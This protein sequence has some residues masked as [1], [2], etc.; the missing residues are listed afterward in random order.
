[1]PSGPIHD[2]AG[3]FQLAERL[4][5][6]PVADAAGQPTVANPIGL[7]RTPATY[8]LAPPPLGGDVVDLDGQV[9]PRVDGQ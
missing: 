4:G 7:S 9:H 3:A 5:L 6:A 8:R 2:L 1:M